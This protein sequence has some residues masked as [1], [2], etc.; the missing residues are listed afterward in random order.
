MQ[1][2]Y[3]YPTIY[4]NRIVFVSEDNLWLVNLDTNGGKAQ[5]LTANLEEVTHP[6]LSPDGKWIAFVGMEEGNS[7]VYVMPSDDGSSERL[8]FLAAIAR[9]LAGATTG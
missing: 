9:R 8:T 6:F 4:R 1:G 2:Y 3:R 7:E 5:R